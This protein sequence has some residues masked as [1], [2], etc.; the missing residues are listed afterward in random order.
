M[1][2]NSNVKGERRKMAEMTAGTN[3]EL[4]PIVHFIYFGLFFLVSSV[5][6]KGQSKPGTSA[7][8]PRSLPFLRIRPPW[9]GGN[10]A[11]LA[12]VHPTTCDK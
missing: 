8:S 10:R 5:I 3:T 12:E 1:Q 2:V 6:W 9:F 11:V 7:A 4:L